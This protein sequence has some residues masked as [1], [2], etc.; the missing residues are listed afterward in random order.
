MLLMK[1]RPLTVKMGAVSEKSHSGVRFTAMI[2][3]KITAEDDKIKAHKETVS[4][5]WGFSRMASLFV[6]HCLWEC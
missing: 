5:F 2:Q 1:I 3:P 4:G 6:R